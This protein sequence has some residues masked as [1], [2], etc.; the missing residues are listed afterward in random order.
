MNIAII[1]SGGIGSRMGLDIP[2]QYVEVE[3]KPVIAYCFETFINDSHID[4]IVIGCAEEWLDY[5]REMVEKSR[6]VKPVLYAPSGETRQYSIYHAL[7]VAE[8]ISQSN[9]DVVIIHDAARPL[10]SP[11]LIARCIEG[12]NNA[13][14]VMPVLP[15]KDTVYLSEDGTHIKALLNRNQLC[16]GQAPE[17]FRL[18][19][20]LQEHERISREELLKINGSTEL[21]FKAG[22]VC[23]MVEGDPMNFK[24]TTPEDLS[25]FRSIILK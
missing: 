2:K 4:A 6:T 14:G 16:A 22:M 12:C 9:E 3:G 19:R 7:K 25:N 23:R 15:V 11:E 13:E 17:A 10:V 1:L 20:Y 8:S 5:V 18:H 21:A 24:I